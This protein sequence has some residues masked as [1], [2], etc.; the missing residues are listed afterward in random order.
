MPSF[1]PRLNLFK[2]APGNR[3]S[4]FDL[5]VYRLFCWRWNPILRDHPEV[6]RRFQEYMQNWAAE[7]EQMRA[8]LTLVP[9]GK[10]ESSPI[11]RSGAQ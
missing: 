2:P 5:W 4:R 1:L 8:E 6:R 11:V 9:G 3:F 7:R 10:D